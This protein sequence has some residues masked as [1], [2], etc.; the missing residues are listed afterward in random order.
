M[1]SD[2]A[3]AGTDSRVYMVMY[4]QDGSDSGRLSLDKPGVNLFERAQRDVFEVG[5][6]LP[7]SVA[8]IA[9]DDLSAHSIVVGHCRS[10]LLSWTPCSSCASVTITAAMAAPG[11]WNM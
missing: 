7:P 11:T 5:A 4:G 2:L 10:R 8:G 3:G 9:C 1:T 6:L